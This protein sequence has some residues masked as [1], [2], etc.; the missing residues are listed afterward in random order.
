MSAARASQPSLQNIDA[1]QE[2]MTALSRS[3]NR[4]PITRIEWLVI[5]FIVSQTIGNVA[6]LIRAIRGH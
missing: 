2:A 6:M 1:V 3:T 4:V 5:A